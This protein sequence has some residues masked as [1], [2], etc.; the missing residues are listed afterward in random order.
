MLVSSSARLVTGATA[1]RPA[2]AACR[3][4]RRFASKLVEV[5][6]QTEIPSLGP[7]GARVAVSPGTARNRL[8]PSGQALYVGRDGLAVSPL[9]RMLRKEAERAGGI[10]E[11]MKREREREAERR[12]KRV[13]DEMSGVAHDPHA[14]ARA[15]EES[16]LGSLALLPQPLPFKRLTTSPTSSDLFGSV[17]ASDVLATLKEQNVNLDAHVGAAFREQDGVEKGRVKRLGE[18]VFS[19]PFKVLESEYEVKVK[20]DKA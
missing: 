20:V 15:A 9:G 14:A 7:R 17:S 12:A 1:T 16:L 3:T 18:F 11:V 6:L 8:I 13:L 4:Q 10:A 5:E 2:C 19:V